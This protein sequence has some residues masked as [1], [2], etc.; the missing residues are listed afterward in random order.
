MYIG[1]LWFEYV[2]SS[3]CSFTSYTSSCEESERLYDPVLLGLSLLALVLNAT[4][5]SIFAQQNR[6]SVMRIS[7]LLLSATEVVFHLFFCLDYAMR[8]A[9]CS[10]PIEKP[11]IMTTVMS[12]LINFG[13]DAF[14]CARNW[15]NVLITAARTEV[16]VFPLR[17]RR[18]FTRRSTVLI[19]VFLLTLACMLASVRAFFDQAGICHVGNNTESL[20]LEI[21]PLM[22]SHVIKHYEAYGYFIYQIILPILLVLTMSTIICTY[23]SPWCQA[24]IL[25]ASTIRRRHQMNATRTVLIIALTFL[26]FQMPSFVFVILHNYTGIISQETD[27][28]FR[29]KIAQALADTL[30]VL[31]SVINILIYSFKIPGFRNQLCCFQRGH[32]AT[33]ETR[34]D[35]ITKDGVTRL[36]YTP[37]FRSTQ[38]KRTCSEVDHHELNAKVPAENHRNHGEIVQT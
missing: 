25:E 7:L 10:I 35:F 23:V 16:I 6:Q 27:S 3:N 4:C 32:A 20:N 38:K 24:E 17:S 5:M 18:Y 22:P 9:V 30:I 28:V 36:T 12:A 11:T 14:I 31:D 29:F 34:L 26:S 8:I 13:G 21:L 2:N 19:Y 1:T 15:C 37:S 33:D